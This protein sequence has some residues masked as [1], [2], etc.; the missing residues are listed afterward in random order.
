[1]FQ[2]EFTPEFK[3]NMTNS[4]NYEVDSN[5][6]LYVTRKNAW[7]FMSLFYFPTLTSI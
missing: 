4:V 2:L 7:N 1:L 5:K 6:I 3:I